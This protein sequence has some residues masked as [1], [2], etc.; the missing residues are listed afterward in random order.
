MPLASSSGW[1][2]RTSSAEMSCVGC[3]AS[4]YSLAIARCC[5]A[6]TSRSESPFITRRIEP[7]RWRPTPPST[8]SWSDFIASSAAT[9]TFL[10]FGEPPKRVTRP[11]A[12]HVAPAHSCP[13]FS[14]RVTRTPRRERE[15]ASET[16]ATPPPIMRAEEGRRESGAEMWN[17]SDGRERPEDGRGGGGVREIG[18]DSAA[19]SVQ[20][21]RKEGVRARGK[22]GR[23]ARGCKEWEEEW[24]K[25]SA[26]REEA[27]VW[28]EGVRRE[29]VRSEV[30]GARGEARGKERERR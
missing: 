7:V 21:C 13:A 30:F 6:S 11:A 8:S 5:L 29:G 19:G 27:S 4:S 16:P 28:R 24:E 20:T 1:S 23:R 12:C 25:E 17:E 9:C 14:S 10:S 2:A 26:E 22:V 3:C 18:R 15:E